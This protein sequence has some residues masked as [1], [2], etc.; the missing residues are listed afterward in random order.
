[1]QRLMWFSGVV[2]QVE[3]DI[4]IG[5]GGDPIDHVEGKDGKGHPPE[6]RH[7]GSVCVDWK[8]QGARMTLHNPHHLKSSRA[9]QV[10]ISEHRTLRMQS[11]HREGR[12][13]PS[14]GLET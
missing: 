8:Q 13:M 14:P 11:T 3:G 1:M 10:L 9:T 7:P 4:I 6:R 2:R 5:C 12:A